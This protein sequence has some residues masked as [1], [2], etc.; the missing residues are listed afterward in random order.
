MGR[1]PG[2]G[3][4]LDALNKAYRQGNMAGTLGMERKCCPYR[5]AVVLSAWEAGWEDGVMV[6]APVHRASKPILP[7]LP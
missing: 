5:G 4:N 1:E 6:S 3:R 2:L 7:D